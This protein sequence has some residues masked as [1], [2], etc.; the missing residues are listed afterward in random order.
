MCPRMPISPPNQP[1]HGRGH[2]FDPCITHQVHE[3]ATSGWR[4]S[5]CYGCWRGITVTPTATAWFIDTSMW[6]P[7][8]APASAVRSFTG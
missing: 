1:S 7:G 2:M 5:W 8:R 4:F 6:S 3:N